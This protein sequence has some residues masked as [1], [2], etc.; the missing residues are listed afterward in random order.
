[1]HRILF[2][3]CALW[4]GAA[5]FSDA[6][7]NI[8]VGKDA[9]TDGSVICTY[10]CD[11]FGYAGWLTQ[12]PA[13]VHEPGEKIAIRDFWHPGEIR[14]YVDQVPY[15][16]QV[17]GYMNEH[18]LTVVETTFGGRK[19]LTDPS[20]ILGYD[21]LMQL[22]LQRCTTAREAILCMGK[23]VEE[24]GY[25]Q[26]GET[27]TVCDKQEAWM[28]DLIGK[29]PG[30]TGAVW[31]A[32]RIP[33]DCISAHANHSRIRRFPQARKPDRKTGFCEI[34]GVCI[35]SPDVIS[36]AREMG[37]YDGNDA[38]FS[39]RD[40]Y[41]PLE[42]VNMRLCEPRVWSFFRHHT[43]P[44]EMDRYLPYLDGQ[45]EVCDSLPLWIRPDRKLSLQDVMADMRDHF[46]G[47]PLDMTADMSAGPWGSPIRPRA[48]GFV[49]GGKQYFRERP[50]STQQAGFCL[51]AQ[52]RS[53]L[54]DAVGGVYHFNCD[55]PCMVAYVPVY[56]GIT[57]LPEAFRAQHN[58]DG[59]FDEKGAF[60]LCN[61][62][63]N[64]VYPRWSAM[65]GDLKE[66]R[67]EL[68]DRFAAEQAEVEETAS[69][70]TPSERTA[71]LN[72]KTARY[73]QEMMERWA[74]LSRH[75]IVKYNDQPGGWDQA[76]Y[77]AI[78]VSTGDRY[79]VPG[80]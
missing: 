47:T 51:V 42:F 45:F 6:C 12:S 49:S 66:A 3:S 31:V 61:F 5:L 72:E 46:E 36:F 43:D 44:A 23:L 78:A 38:D 18:Q 63:S 24:Y 76:F 22:A 11:T 37:Y 53:W 48:K 19:E 62:V 67:Q 33:D 59:V 32:V 54:P 8:I 10:N 7:T 64:M 28:M 75:L 27:F 57:E 50:I 58:Q 16:Y 74:S 73:T 9:S 68:E 35:Y 70:L 4:M 34:P 21:N 69:R 56:C 52:M 65:I 41:C 20:G 80:Q 26:T 30:R 29:G 2:L 14:G 79:L 15:T 40:A 25:C 55:D 77:D 17:V 39:F 60:W 1:M 71:Y 13:G